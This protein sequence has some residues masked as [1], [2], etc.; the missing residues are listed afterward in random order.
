MC[1]LPERE[2]DGANRSASVLFALEKEGHRETMEYVDSLLERLCPAERVLIV[3]REIE[4]L[5]LEEVAA[6]LGIGTGALRVR[7][8]RA[9]KRL[10]AALRREAPRVARPPLALAEL[11]R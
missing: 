8:F 11:E 10:R 4:G 6:V 2:V 1:D 3:M 5:S 7:L 9:R